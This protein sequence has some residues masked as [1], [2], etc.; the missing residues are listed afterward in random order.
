MSVVEVGQK[1]MRRPK[2]IRE[3]TE[4]NHLKVVPMKGKVVYVHPKHRFHV[5]EFENRTGGTFRES[6]PGVEV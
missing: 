2:T 5:V 3:L 6:F 1:V 4:E